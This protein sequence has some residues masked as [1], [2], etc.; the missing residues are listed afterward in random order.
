MDVLFQ[1]KL[2]KAK[3]NTFERQNKM[4]AMSTS[5]TMPMFIFSVKI[6]LQKISCEHYSKNILNPLSASFI[7]LSNT[8]KQ[9][10]GKLPMNCLSVFDH[11]VG[12]A[13]KGLSFLTVF[14]YDL[15][16]AES[17]AGRWRAAWRLQNLI[18]ATHL[19]LFNRDTL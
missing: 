19:F 8:L 14:A 18:M 12:L 15:Y 16:K 4:F 2:K 17:R 6:Q 3:I 10:V 5:K 11:F 1:M 7:K 9:F 13:L